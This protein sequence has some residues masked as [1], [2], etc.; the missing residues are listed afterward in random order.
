[1]RAADLMIIVAVWG[2]ATAVCGPGL[3]RKWREKP[4][5]SPVVPGDQYSTTNSSGVIFYTTGTNLILDT[6]TCVL[7]TWGVIPGGK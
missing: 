6:N 3:M 4:T 5:P 1:M 2:I 7:P